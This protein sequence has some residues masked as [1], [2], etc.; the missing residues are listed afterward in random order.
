MVCASAGVVACEES[1]GNLHW[2]GTGIRP[3]E[4]QLHYL[5]GRERLLRWDAHLLVKVGLAWSVRA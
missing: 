1:V 4:K 5:G 2:A 3:I